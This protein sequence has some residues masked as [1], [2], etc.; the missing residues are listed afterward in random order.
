MIFWSS[1]NLGHGDDDE[2]PCRQIA[3]RVA[4]YPRRIEYPVDEIGSEK[5]AE[6]KTRVHCALPR[7]VEE[8]TAAPPS[9]ASKTYKSGPNNLVIV[10][11]EREARF[12]PGRDDIRRTRRS[13]PFAKQEADKAYGAGSEP[14]AAASRTTHSR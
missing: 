7:T 12:E 8:T 11:T 2:I 4:L 6:R 10:R 14:I 3:H 13:N 9:T 1:I 5:M